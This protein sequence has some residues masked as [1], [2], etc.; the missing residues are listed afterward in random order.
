MSQEAR[1]A[2]QWWLTDSPW[3]ANGNDIV[4]TVRPIQTTLR[5]DAATHN[6]G[7]GGV[8]TLGSKEFKTRGCLTEE[9]QREVYINQHEF[10]GFENT[11]WSLLPEAVPDRTQWPKVH[12]SVE[13]GNVTS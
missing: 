2:L 5:T 8:M 12:V 9:E 4:P 3:K 7:H 1:K 13:L 10:M 6:A 11:L